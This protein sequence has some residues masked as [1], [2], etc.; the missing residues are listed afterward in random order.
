M[1]KRAFKNIFRIIGILFIC[2]LIFLAIICGYL[3]GTMILV[4]KE[5]PQVDTDALLSGLNEN[6]TIIDSNG[7]LI[8]TLETE[9]FREIVPYD[10]IPINLV[11]AIVSSEDKRFWEHNGIDFLGILST[12]KDLASS[13]SLR[14]A[15]TLTMQTARN[16]YLN[17]DVNWERKIQEIMIS[18][19]MEHDLED[20]YGKQTAKEKILEAYL[21]RVFFGQSAYGV[22]AAAQIYFSKNVWELDLAQCATIAGVVQ[23]PSDYALYWLYR[24]SEIS[25][26]RILG[27]TTLNGEKY[28]AVY[29]DLPYE[30]AK[31]VLER[32]LANGYI[33]EEEYNEAINEDVAATIKPPVKRA[34]N[35]STY[36]TD[37]VKSD[38]IQILMDTKN[39]SEDDA[40]HLFYYGGLKITS[41]VD[42]D[43]QRKLQDKLQDLNYIL[44]GDTEGYSGPNNLELN[45]DSN[46]NIL[47]EDDGLEYYAKS[48][49]VTGDNEIF[50]P[51][52]QYSFREDGSL[53]ITPGRIEAYT[54]YLD[55]ADFYTTDDYGILRTHRSGTIPIKE[56]YLSTDSE[57]KIVIS[58]EFLKQGKPLYRV[59]EDG[60]L[61][62]SKEYYQIDIVGVTQPQVAMTIIDNKTGEVRA[63]V[64]GREQ[65]DERHFLNRAA[66]YPR[67][68]GSS[69]KPLAVY[70]GVFGSGYNAA[71]VLDDTPYELQDSDPWP[72]NVN[73]R[74]KG[75]TTVDDA[76]V[77]STNT[78]AVKW[79]NTIGIAKSK[80]YL[81]KFGIIN[82][83]HPDRD[84]FVEAG[85]NS[86]TNDEN[87]AMSLGALTNGMTTLNI[88]SAYQTFGNNGKHI[89][90]SSISKIV[91][92]N[93]N[94]IYENP[95]KEIEVLPP[96]VNYQLLGCLKNVV[97]Y[98]SASDSIP[99]FDIELAGKT[100]TTESHADFWFAST[101]P[102]Y[103]SAVWLGVDN[104]R[105]HL[106]GN[107]ENCAIVYSAVHDMIHEGKEDKT[108]DEPE[109]LYEMQICTK[110]GKLPTDACYADE[111]GTVSTVLVSD[112]TAPHDSCGVH[113]FRKIDIRN[114]LLAQDGTPDIL[115][116]SKSFI[117]R[118]NP[119]Y[120]PSD[121]N[122][123][124][125]EDWRYEAPYRTSSLPIIITPVEVTNSDGSV[126]TTTY[127]QSTWAK[128]ETTVYPN[129]K[130][131][132][133]VTELNGQ[134]TTT[135]T[136]KITTTPIVPDSENPNIIN[137]NSSDSSDSSNS[138]N[139]SDSSTGN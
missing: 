41:T 70:A 128:I 48:N 39:I 91:D 124:T 4:A 126:T 101:T 59:D 120:N 8:Q 33:T 58:S 24:P 97:K 53:V 100:G 133:V 30:R 103:S 79:L 18:L 127:D 93:D 52:D 129:G 38:A 36:L 19:K 132:K 138:S 123:I 102:Y 1:G 5:T 55:L 11:N 118:N 9:E 7:N 134:V 44:N 107:S 14:G 109:G 2:F 34:E 64:G 130:T 17:L 112:E 46:D 137:Q 22:Q 3:A 56:E 90:A 114:N 104:A 69:F 88:A 72:M 26:E 78:I 35:L 83:E 87:L 50:L 113:V 76:I 15:S 117:I 37:L 75:L 111:R 125:P 66:F 110:S 65:I 60:N 31:Y 23:A 99:S 71:S 81:T 10:K 51:S 40:Y 96:Q 20:K 62:L 106:E 105:L 74:W 16:T 68:P 122:G 119:P 28:F 12:F 61:I 89:A 121:F 63:I 77:N 131:V 67:Q 92:G 13:G 95:H 54:D 135:T 98:G 80:E 57:G 21:N 85:E 25:D 49:L 84:N 139:S 86:E 42:L 6:S 108:F 47:N 115:T 116:K 43:M 136:E 82:A 27:E 29:N 32:M 45:Y 94:V 73:Y